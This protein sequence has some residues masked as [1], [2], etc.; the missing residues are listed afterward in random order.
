MTRLIQALR[1][2]QCKR[3]GHRFGEIK[4]RAVMDED[5]VVGEVLDMECVRCGHV[6]VMTSWL[7]Q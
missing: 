3:K 1:R 2:W 4:L 5:V 6:Q 7:Y